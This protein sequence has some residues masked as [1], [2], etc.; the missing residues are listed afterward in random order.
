MPAIL[1][2]AGI[3][4][5]ARLRFFYVLHPAKFIKTLKE[6]AGEGG[7]SPLR[8]L[9]QALAGTLGVGNMAGVAT[10]ITAGGAGA[11][12][13]MWLSAFAAMSVKYFEVYLGVRHRRQD[14]NGFFG[15]AMY[16]IR[17][18][19]KS[20]FPKM[21]FAFGGA[22]AVLCIANS[23]MTGNIVQ[24]KAAAEVFPDIPPLVIGV[25]LAVSALAVAVFSSGKADK[26]S[27]VTSVIIPVL[28]AAF[29]V[30][31]LAV[32]VRNIADVPTVIG[33]IFADAFSLRPALGGTGG[34]LIMRA[35]RFGTTRGVFSNEAGCGTSPT[36]HA[37]ANAKSPHHQGCFGIFEVFADTVVLCTLTALVIL[38][39]GVPASLD[40]IPLTL[41]A[42]TKLAGGISGRIIGVS[43]ILFAFATVICQTQ[44]AAEALRYFTKSRS[45]KYFYFLISFA[46][47]VYGTVI[48]S[49]SMWLW[50]DFII[51]LMTVLNIVCLILSKEKPYKFI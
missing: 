15:G 38:L 6:S 43:V 12:F 41:F 22:F 5:G 37:S 10:A 51:S 25:T 23:L 45:V 48:Q 16:Y 32:I 11:V 20:Y 17:D 3:Y 50:C 2:I 27:A 40:G 47:T 19:T 34:F 39:A 7:V 42:Y 8:A 31:S 46:A 44:Y 24:M 21:S 36:A 1:I 4:F 18:I 33:K 30:I 14:K 35:V 28:C 29:F 13:W 26:V 9:T 49:E